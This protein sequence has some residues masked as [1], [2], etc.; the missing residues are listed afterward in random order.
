M[1]CHRPAK[2][3]RVAKVELIEWSTTYEHVLAFFS[4]EL[5]DFHRMPYPRVHWLRYTAVV[6]RSWYL[7]SREGSTELYYWLACPSKATASSVDHLGM[8][9]WWGIRCILVAKMK[10]FG[11]WM[12]IGKRLLLTEK[13]EEYWWFTE[14]Y[15]VL[16]GM[17]SLRYI[18][19]GKA[20]VILLILIIRIRIMQIIMSY[21][22]YM[23]LPR[24]CSGEFFAFCN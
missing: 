6:D 22:W 13:Y 16:I 10:W 2:V 15:S 5:L 11:E 12:E 7:W 8:E 18:D 20:G 21:T 24:F 23:I 3:F 19:C 17:A 14:R 9:R 1:A 4:L